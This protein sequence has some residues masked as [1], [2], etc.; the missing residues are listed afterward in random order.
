MRAA[1]L[2]GAFSIAPFANGA[3]IPS[4]AEELWAEIRNAALRKAADFRYGFD[5]FSVTL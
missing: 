1:L 2:V 3:R 4:T 5:F